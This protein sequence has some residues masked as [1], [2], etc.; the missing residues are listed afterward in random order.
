MAFNEDL[1][2]KVAKRVIK[3]PRTATEIG[4]PLGYSGRGV[5]RVLRELVEDGVITKSD[6]RIPTYTKA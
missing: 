5:G 1:K 4:E 6:D 3:K 2:K